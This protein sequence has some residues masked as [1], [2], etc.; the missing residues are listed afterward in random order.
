[1][2]KPRIL[3]VE[4]E[5]EIADL[6]MSALEEMG[7]EVASVVSTGEEAIENA[8]TGNIDLILMDIV[9]DSEMTGT[10]AAEKIRSKSNIP[11]I[12]LT[13]Y[14]NKH[15]IQ[16]AKL[17][18][19]YGYLIKPFNDKELYATIEMALYKNNLEK[20]KIRIN[21][22]LRCTRNINKH[23]EAER[24][25]K[26]L[27][28]NI[29]HN[30]IETNDFYGAWIA[31]IDEKNNVYETAEA[32]LGAA[33]KTILEYFKKE[34]LNVKFSKTPHQKKSNKNFDH[35]SE[36][37]YASFDK[38][39]DQES[40]LFKLESEG[41][42]LG[43]IALL[44]KDKNIET[45]EISLLK[46][47]AVDVV[48]ALKRIEL[49]EKNRII[50]QNLKEAEN[51]YRQVVENAVDIIFTTD[52]FGN[53]I[54][55]NKSCSEFSGF[56]ISE[57]LKLN[58][59]DLINPEYREKT[60]RFF[61][62]QYLTKTPTTYFEYSF[63]LKNGR[64]GWL[65]Q[66]TSLIYE[67]NKIIGFHCISRDITEAKQI[68]MA[69]KESEK[70]YRHLVELSPDAIIVHVKGKIIYTNGACQ[71]LFGAKKE[72][73]LL[74]KS[75][76]EFIQPNSIDT[77]KAKFKYK[78][79]N[80]S[81]KILQD[82]KLNRFDG[83]EINIETSTSPVIFNNLSATQVIIRDITD[84]KKAEEEHRKSQLEVNTLLDSL[85]GLAFFKDQDLKYLIVNQKFCD[86]MGY[87]K[88]EMIGKTDF[89][90]MPHH[91]A[92]K[93]RAEDLEVLKSGQVLYVREE[94]TF[95]KGKLLTIGTRKVPVKDENGYV[96]GLI[97]LGVDITE[98]KV[99]EEAIKRY[100]KELEELNAEKDKFFSIISH[101]LRSPFQGLLGLT[102]AI[103]E[104]YENLS[105]E[106]IKLFINNIHNS[107]KNLFNLIE[108][109]LQWSRIQRG[110]LEINLAKVDLY[111]AVLY[112]INLLIRNAT[113]K[114]IT[115]INETEKDTFV[116]SDS[117]ILNSTLQNLISNAIKFTHSGG[118]I[119]ISSKI[120]D[121][122]IAVSVSD[123]GIGIHEDDLKKLF[124][125]DTQHSTFGTAKETGTGLGLIICKELI[126]KQ[127][128]T[129]IA[130]S[131]LGE[132]SSFIFK[133]LIFKDE[134]S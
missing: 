29:C 79:V 3:I 104:E 128:G 18:E 9:L 84:R 46:S 85:P 95:V 76:T 51:K 120:E 111:E 17:S 86:A 127:G 118:E 4:D 39:G 7:Y 92:S 94:Q 81:A 115:I 102:N 40:L 60:K 59:S 90:L 131:K 41:K 100:T 34:I 33:F 134:M 96:I 132:G 64:T 52:I 69:L 24:D 123:N 71:K 27:I 107:S 91:A 87:A 66:N 70:R 32:G 78:A 43:V 89:D 11:I 28:Q 12:F 126:E 61:L 119:R 23:L 130:E 73:E 56:S 30:L 57:L 5:P 15:L 16:N 35:D 49:E 133:L 36:T 63:N 68:Q 53:F 83:V 37:A 21:H 77:I 25:R 80:D 93:Y 114:D 99:A 109:L 129:I 121:G 1:M 74:N 113:N 103:M 75:I 14:L 67:N 122:F 82:Q 116:Y 2:K 97:G 98:R 124:R 105:V 13:A 101:D 19:P 88:E 22:L 54:Y 112:V 106:E 10:N 26:K 65:G 45:E 8:K 58:Y 48:Y 125:I 47:I 117:N 20:N 108:N 38:F 44:L 55:A 110:K 6:I 42:N 72:E 62:R 31:L 50:E